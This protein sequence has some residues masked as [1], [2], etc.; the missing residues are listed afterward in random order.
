MLRGAAAAL[1]VLFVAIQF[2]PV[3]RSAP[4]ITQDV[5]APPEVAALLR[6][7][8]Y[9]CHSRETRWPWYAR[10]APASW[11]VARDVRLGRGNLD[12]SGWDAY[13]ADERR[14]LRREAWEEV[15]SDEMPPTLYRLMHP[16]ARLGEAD[17]AVLR[18]WASAPEGPA[19][20]DED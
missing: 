11:L 7:A 6:R 10:I 13:D 1:I 8:C 18:A 12:F 20:R 15:G 16:E 14:H 19:P 4:A 5:A 3:D 9:D 17:R 2:V